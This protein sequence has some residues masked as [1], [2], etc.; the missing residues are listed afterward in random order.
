MVSSHMTIRNLLRFILPSA[1][2][3]L[4]FLVPINFNGK[5]SIGLGHLMDWF[6]IPFQSY[7]FELVLS[8]I[9]C[10]ALGSLYYIIFKPD[11][12][13]SHPTLHGMFKVSTAWF[14]LRIAAAILSLMVYFNFGP[15]VILLEDTGPLLIPLIG[16][17][18][19]FALFVSYFFLPLL[20]DF[21]LL[22]FAGTLI[23]RPFEWL[24][25]LPGRAAIDATSSI[26]SASSVGIILTIKQYEDGRYTGREAASVATNFSIVSLPFCLVIAETA[27]LSYMFFSWYLTVLIAC[28]VCAAIMVRL[29]P[30]VKITDEYIAATGQ[31]VHEEKAQGV[32]IFRWAL[33]QGL[34]CAKSAR[35]APE[36]ISHSWHSV[37]I[38]LFNING[39]HTSSLC[40]IHYK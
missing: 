14:L 12:R 30:L 2:G 28:L 37:W 1:M 6:K 8:I 13:D 32:S 26:V 23:R 33:D 34:A 19:F 17:A 24:F 4:I 22:E 20:T 15:E 39:Y 11:W 16:A 38:I 27:D 3:V 36:I 5:S 35:S 25:T 18:V 7:E 10:S 29:P 9:I 40:S 31:Q 21:G